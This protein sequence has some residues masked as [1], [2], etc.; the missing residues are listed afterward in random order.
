[1]ECYTD[2]NNK[3]IALVDNGTV[4]MDNIGNESFDASTPLDSSFELVNR[5]SFSVGGELVI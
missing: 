1:M 2:G 4:Y 5:L 3:I